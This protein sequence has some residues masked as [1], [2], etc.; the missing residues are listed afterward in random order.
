MSWSATGNSNVNAYMIG[1]IGGFTHGTVYPNPMTD[2]F[3]GALFGN[4]VT[5]AQSATAGVTEYANQSAGSTW[6]TYA[7]NSTAPPNNYE[8]QNSG[9]GGNPYTAGGSAITAT[10]E[11]SPNAL[12]NS[13]WGL[14]S[15]TSLSWTGATL[16]AYGVLVYDSTVGSTGTHPV[17]SWNYFG[18]LQSVTAGTFTVTWNANGIATFSC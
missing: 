7:Q 6:L 17:F 9:S 18:G 11:Q 1:I 12:G 4:G 2:T 15:N 10:W 3:Y 8:C 14:F 5:P 16:S 13:Y